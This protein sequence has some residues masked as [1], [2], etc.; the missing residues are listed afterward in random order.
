MK[1][2]EVIMI[3]LTIYSLERK[4]PKNLNEPLGNSSI[5]GINN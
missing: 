5:A 1:I 3:Q 4:R 2:F